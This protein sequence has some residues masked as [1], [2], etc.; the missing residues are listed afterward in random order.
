MGEGNERRYTRAFDD[1]TAM[2]IIEVLLHQKPRVVRKCH[3]SS[4]P[5]ARSSCAVAG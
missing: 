5:T 2:K 3:V 1:E 4:A